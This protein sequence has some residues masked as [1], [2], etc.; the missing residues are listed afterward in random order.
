MSCS[1]PCSQFSILVRRGEKKKIGLENLVKI[2]RMFSLA[3]FS[4]GMSPLLLWLFIDRK[5]CNETDEVELKDRFDD[6]T[7]VKKIEAY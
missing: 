2:A 4:A 7:F 6:E 5:N 3:S 1:L